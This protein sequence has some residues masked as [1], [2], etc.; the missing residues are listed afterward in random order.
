VGNDVVAVSAQAAEQPNAHVVVDVLTAYFVSINNRDFVTLRSL[1]TSAIQAKLSP[2]R[3]AEGYRSTYDSDIH[4][5]QIESL[6]DGR[7]AAWVDFV[8]TQD[9]VDGPDGQT[10]TVWSIALF[11]EV[12]GNRVVIGSPPTTY[13][14]SYEAC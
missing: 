1:F 12:E 8:S 10:C 7:V 14:A 3:L 13:Q 2:E 6:A 4:L 9:A 5:R 11:L